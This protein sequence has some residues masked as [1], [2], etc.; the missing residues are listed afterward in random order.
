MNDEYINFAESLA[1]DDGS[2]KISES[3]SRDLRRYNRKLT[4]EQEAK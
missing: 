3:I 1:Q 4:E 2:N